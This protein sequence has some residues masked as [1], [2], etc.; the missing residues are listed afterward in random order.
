[1]LRMNEQC[2]WQEKS[3]GQYQIALQRHN[4]FLTDYRTEGHLDGAR[5]GDRSSGEDSQE[6]AREDDVRCM[7]YAS[8]IL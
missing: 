6:S 5:T 7:R 2:Q 1:M 3:N 4:T 8:M